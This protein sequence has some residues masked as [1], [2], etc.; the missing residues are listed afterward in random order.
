MNRL[1]RLIGNILLS[2][3]KDLSFPY[4]LNFIL[5]YRCNSRCIMCKI[6]QR[7]STKEMG[8]EDI[9]R[10]FKYSNRFSWIDLSGGEIFLKGGLLDIIQIIIESCPYLYI[11]H[12]PTNGLLTDI[13]VSKTKKILSLWRRKLVVTISLDGPAEIHDK[14]RGIDNAWKRSLETYKM[15]RNFR[16]GNFD[17]FLGTTL[18]KENIDMFKL[19]YSSVKKQIPDIAYSDF[20]INLPHSCSHY[21]GEIEI[22]GILQMQLKKAIDDILE[23]K[24][25]SLNPFSFL[26][27][28]YLNLAKKYLITNRSPLS[29]QALSGSCFID[30][31]GDI[32]P[33]SIYSRK[34]G[35]LTDFNFD[36]GQAWGSPI[37]IKTR[38]NISQG[39][40]NQCW[41]PCEA[42]LAIL[43]NLLSSNIWK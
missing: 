18:V 37:F 2:N 30:P 15:L 14:V 5:T 35:N 10:F 22:D 20:H 41:T 9:K 4:R 16:S 34:L 3:F 31:Q 21:Y 17:V 19:T 13:I 36:L 27:W 11:L 7:A 42:Y 40:C 6:W 33:C 39:E 23:L 38:E 29:C 32:Y 26:E 25:L 43:G 1:F 28:R 8:L 24:H 12:F